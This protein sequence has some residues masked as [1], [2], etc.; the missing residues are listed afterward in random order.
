MQTHLDK[1]VSVKGDHH[2]CCLCG[3][4]CHCSAADPHVPVLILHPAP[5]VYLYPYGYAS[6]ACLVT[7]R[8]QV[9]IKMGKNDYK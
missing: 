7:M 2:D 5:L 1:P 3:T 6:G 9:V 8:L 4:D